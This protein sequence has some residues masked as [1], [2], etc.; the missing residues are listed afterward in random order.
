MQFSLNN[1]Y[2]IKYLHKIVQMHI[3]TKFNGIKKQ[4]IKLI[5]I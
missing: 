5:V 4:L 3:I 2:S 1:N